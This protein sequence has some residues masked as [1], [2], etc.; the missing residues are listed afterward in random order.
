MVMAPFA[1]EVVTIIGSISG[2]RPTAIEMAN[3]PA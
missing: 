1:S 2:V 3:S